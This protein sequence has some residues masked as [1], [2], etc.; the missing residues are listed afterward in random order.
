MSSYSATLILPPRELNIASIFHIMACMII[1]S[2]NA[3]VEGK[4]R[5][6]LLHFYT[7]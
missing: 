7:P 5:I 2:D 6:K 3:C 4:I 1:L